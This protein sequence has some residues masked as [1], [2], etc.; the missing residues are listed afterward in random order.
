VPVRL[1]EVLAAAVLTAA[2]AGAGSPVPQPRRGA[3]ATRRPRRWND[4]DEKLMIWGM[5]AVAGLSVYAA[6]FITL[7]VWL[8]G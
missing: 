8:S 6:V 1:S 2:R 5:L 7:A 4:P 3:P